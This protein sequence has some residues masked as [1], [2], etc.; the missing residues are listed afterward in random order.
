MINIHEKPEKHEK[1]DGEIYYKG[2]TLRQTY[3]PESD[4][5]ALRFAGQHEPLSASNHWTG[6][7]MKFFVPFA[8]FV[9]N[10]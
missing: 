10:A 4:G 1:I 8:F 9:D 3:V 6:H 7:A 2:D 5:N